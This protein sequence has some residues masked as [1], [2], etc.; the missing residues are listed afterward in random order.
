MDRLQVAF[1]RIKAITDEEN[2]NVIIASMMNLA[3]QISE[4]GLGKRKTIGNTTLEEA[5]R[6]VI[7]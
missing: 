4:L 7:N 5:K 3:G 1:N 2:E 6:E